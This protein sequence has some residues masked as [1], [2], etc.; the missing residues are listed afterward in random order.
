MNETMYLFSKY[1]FMFMRRKTHG[2]GYS[3][4]KVSSRLEAVIE[5]CEE[6]K[7]QRKSFLEKNLEFTTPR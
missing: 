4:I 7:F 6:K 1:I 2:S 3:M 5:D